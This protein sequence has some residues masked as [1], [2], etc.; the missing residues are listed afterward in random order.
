MDLTRPAPATDA[1]KMMMYDANKKSAGI[2][3]VLWF[4]IGGLGGHRFYAGKTGSAVAILL[5][6][7]LSPFTAFLSLAVVG[8]WATRLGVRMVGSQVRTP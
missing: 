6:S 2:A 1:M 4:L 3:Y 7:I 5:L 8:I